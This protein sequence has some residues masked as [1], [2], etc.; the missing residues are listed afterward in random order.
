MITNLPIAVSAT[1][2]Q[3]ASTITE[4]LCQAFCTNASIQPIA[5]VSYSVGSIQVANGTAFVTINASGS[6]LYYPKGSNT[7]RTK[8]FNESFVVAFV[9]TGT[10]TIALTQTPNVEGASNIKC[11]NRAYGYTITT[12]V[13]ITATFA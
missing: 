4:N 5:D 9:G 7:T 13:T 6:I 3:Y 11:C 8:L 12:N 2:Q 10:P 1:S